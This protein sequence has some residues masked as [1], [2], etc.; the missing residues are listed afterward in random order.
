MPSTVYPYASDGHSNNAQGT[1]EQGRVPAGRGAEGDKL[2]PNQFRVGSG[3]MLIASNS[4]V[5]T[6]IH[7]TCSLR[8]KIMFLETEFTRLPNWKHCVISWPV[9]CSE[10]NI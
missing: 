8:N 5:L 4:Q 1:W 7:I 6:L 2:K 3:W 9:T 10:K